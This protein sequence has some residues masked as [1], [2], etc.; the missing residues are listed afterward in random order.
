MLR[1][2]TILTFMLLPATSFAV[3]EK[4]GVHYVYTDDLEEH[5]AP[6]FKSKITNTLHKGQK[7][8]VFEIKAGWARVSKYYQGDS[9]GPPGNVAR[10]VVAKSLTTVKPFEKQT[11]TV[12]A[13]TQYGSRISPYAIPEAGKNG[14]TEKDVDI[15]R[16]GAIKLLDS[17]ECKRV[18][19]ADKSTTKPNTYYINCGADNIFFKASDIN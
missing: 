14:L 2:L 15:L 11:L 17:G 18:E 7:V 12:N 13:Q 3:A 4:K 6:S 19:Y 10:W 16:Q 1:A 5:L 9:E 8:D